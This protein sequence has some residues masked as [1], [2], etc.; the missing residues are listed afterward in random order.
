MSELPV[1][2]VQFISVLGAECTGKS[3]LCSALATTENGRWIAE[4]VREFCVLY[5][6]PPRQDEQAGVVAE[7]IRRERMAM[8]Q[9]GRVFVD[10]SP[11][12]T[13]IYSIHYFGDRSLLDDALVH[14]RSYAATL[15]CDI[16]LPWI[17][18]GL[19]RDSEAV[20]ARCQSLLRAAL[21]EAHIA[22]T[23]VSGDLATRLAIAHA[24]L[25]ELDPIS[26]APR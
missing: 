11:L 13:A 8:R 17:A 2:Q 10:S 24:R 22:Y 25:G 7:Q 16:D 23:L 20:R 5:D 3:T 6:R 9:P 15:V 19:I 21:D 18:D 1:P 12:M 26:S 4:Y 14:Q